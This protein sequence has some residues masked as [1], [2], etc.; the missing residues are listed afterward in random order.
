MLLLLR[1]WLCLRS[2]GGPRGAVSGR[3]SIAG[4]TAQAITALDVTRSI[5]ISGATWKSSPASSPMTWSFYHDQGGVT[6]GREK[7]TDS[8]KKNICAK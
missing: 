2:R 5:P 1:C 4:G 7:L 8:V 6:L 3:H